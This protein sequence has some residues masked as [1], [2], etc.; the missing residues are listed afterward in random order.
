MSDPAGNTETQFIDLHAHTTASDGTLSPAELVA[1]ALRV[2]L[3]ALAVTDHDTFNGFDA[4]RALARDGGLDLVRGVELNTRLELPNGREHRSA[5][6]LGYWPSREPSERFAQWL[7][8]EQEDRRTR[9]RR[10]AEALQNRGVQITLEE[11]ERAGRSLAGR[12][13]FARL[14][15]AK[16]YAAN[17]EDAFERFLGEH[18]PSYVERESQRTEEAIRVV[19]EGGGVPVLAHP[20]RLSLARDVEAVVVRHLADVGLAGLEI[21]HSEHPPH[22]Q[23][24][25]RQLAEEVSLLPTGGSDFHGTVKPNI[26]LGTGMNAN[27]RVP[28]EFLDRMREFVQ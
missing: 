16:G 23:A 25:Y 14:L 3:S 8:E 24:H 20:I 17:V 10:L 18:A 26:E 5:H 11:V 1:L 2:G 7:R 4:A 21:Y 13:H 19:R 15:V 27:V 9:N 6:L 12:P 22:L 28:R